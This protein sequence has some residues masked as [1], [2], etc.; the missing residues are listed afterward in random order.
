MKKLMKSLLDLRGQQRARRFREWERLR[1]LAYEDE[2]TGVGNLRA[3]R[4]EAVSRI[5]SGKPFGILYLDL[6]RFKKVN[7]TFGHLAGDRVL[8]EVAAVLENEAFSDARAYRLGGD[9]F[10]LIVP[11]VEETGIAAVT[12]RR[13]LDIAKRVRIGS[14]AV[15]ASMG[16][17]RFPQDG[18]TYVELLNA[19]DRRMYTEKARRKEEPSYSFAGD[20]C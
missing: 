18:R 2:L 10:A 20:T 12:L 5:K 1:R 4:E 3:F 14:V 8:R 6:D 11:A 9:E 7:D 19:A 13:E 17:A 16:S 15:G